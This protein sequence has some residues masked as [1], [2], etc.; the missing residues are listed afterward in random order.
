M[1]RKFK[2][3]I[4]TLMAVI[5][6]SVILY[7]CKTESDNTDLQAPAAENTTEPA[8]I[9]EEE[10][11]DN[12]PA[13]DFG[14]YNFR[15]Y[16]EEEDNYTGY[17]HYNDIYV[18]EENGDIL[19]D[20]VFKRNRTVEERFNINITP[21][22]FKDWGTPGE[23]SILSGDDVFDMISTHGMVSYFYA[24]KNLVID[25]AN[26]PYVDLTAAWWN[27][28]IVDNCSYFGKL[29][30]VTGDITHTTLEYTWCMFFNKDLFQNLGIEFPY[31]SVLDGIWTLDRFISIVKNGSADLNGDGALTPDADRYGIDILNRWA[32]P[33]SVLYCGGDKILKKDENGLPVLSVY[34]E[35]T[36]NIYDKFFDMLESGSACIG[37]LR[38]EIYGN[39]G[40]IKIFEEGRALFRDRSL[41][42]FFE[43]RGLEH[44]IGIVPVPKYDEKTLKYYSLMEAGARMMTIPVTVTDFERTSIIVEAMAA[45]GSKTV[46]PVFYEKALKTKHARDDES[47]KMLDI[48][49]DGAVVDYGY[50]NQ[51]LTSDLSLV[52]TKLVESS[53]TN[54][55]SFYEKLEGK[56]LTNIDNFIEANK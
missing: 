4:F 11:S 13:R 50:L 35:R 28:D 16:A 53:N 14:G 24:D 31:Q 20:A 38:H 1:K 17:K 41:G 19:N 56:V 44:E 22:F 15:I 7:S 5:S 37:D 34:N 49:K 18:E 43:Y 47:E 42:G 9:A 2:L 55:A 21:V 40:S 36:R 51:A 29:Y 6:I 32:Y 12:L 30:A 48:I 45:E 23:K 8:N 3:T 26:M 27:Q 33:V 46:L 10:I 54:F 25:W 39:P 52:G